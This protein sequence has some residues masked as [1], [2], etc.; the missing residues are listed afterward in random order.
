MMRMTVWLSCCFA[1]AERL[2]LARRVLVMVA[3]AV[4]MRLVQLEPSRSFASREA[5]RG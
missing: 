4:D 3:G 5:M 1:E 2:R